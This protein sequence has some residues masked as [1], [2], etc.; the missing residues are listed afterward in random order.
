MLFYSQD[1]VFRGGV[2]ERIVGTNFYGT[3]HLACKGSGSRYDVAG[4]ILR[5]MG[6]NDIRLKPVSSDFFKEEYFA[7]RPVSEEMRNYVL[8]LRHM[9]DMPHWKEALKEYLETEFV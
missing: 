7:P 2:I 6:R 5:I 1:T 8:D 3:Y 4:E 9:N